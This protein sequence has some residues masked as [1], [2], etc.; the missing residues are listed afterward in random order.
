VLNVPKTTKMLTKEWPELV[1]TI[2]DDLETSAKEYQALRRRRGIKSGADLLRLILLYAIVLSLRLTA[3]WSVGLQLCDISRQ[4]I[5]KRVLNSTAWLRYLVTVLLHAVVPAPASVSNAIKRLVL[6][7]G[8]VISRPG[9]SGTEWR[10]HL[11]WQPFALQPVELT[12]TDA[13]TGEGLH[14]AGIQAGDLLLADRAYGIWCEIQIVLDALAYLVIRLTWSNLPL[15]TLD[16]QS[17]ALPTWLRSI[18]ESQQMTEVA[19]YVADD[20]DQ[21]PLRLVAG[22]VPPEKAKEA[23]DAV[24]RRARKKQRS[25]HPNTLLAAGFCL[26]LTNLPAL[27]WPIWTILAWY[28]IR[29]QVEWCFRR[30]KSLCYL[31]QLP[32]YPAQIAEP[33]LLAKIIIILLMQ[34]RLGALPWA[35]WWTNPHEPT[36]V[37]STVVQ[38]AYARICDLIRPTA[39]IDR[40]LQ[41]PTPLLRH[42]RSSRRKRPL[43][44]TDALQ[45]LGN[46]FASTALSAPSLC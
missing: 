2:P 21:R 29:W 15:C 22:R 9:S 10:L 46:L 14:D 16:G 45:Q 31:D 5:E 1:K 38:L 11:S 12:T 36:P 43:Q 41:N 35:D 32:A 39:V 7:D 4:A 18:P 23:R 24:Y 6:R 40:L 17:L 30:W 42:L 33:V 3:V 19:V 13:H 34:Q 37:V 44:L 27:T 20:P 28:R 8:S 25:P 26:L